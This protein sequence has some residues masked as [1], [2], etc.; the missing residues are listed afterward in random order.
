MI[1]VNLF[2]CFGYACLYMP[3]KN[4]VPETEVAIGRRVRE[5][6]LRTGLS[7]VRFAQELGIDSSALA[8]YEHGRVPVKYAFVKRLCDRFHVSHR[9][10]A[11]GTGEIFDY[12]EVHPD[13]EQAIS[14]TDLFS[15][16]YGSRLKGGL[17]SRAKL[18]AAAREGGLTIRFQTALGAP[19]S[20]YYR[21]SLSKLLKDHI[22]KVPTAKLPD[23]FRAVSAA[24]KKFLDES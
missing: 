2:M 15:E 19:D 10:L 11:D 24:S 12:D 22:G 17:R 1:P 14:P 7:Q 8:S 16:V 3:R 21:W 18:K 5:L 6:R 13:I 9:W 4:P 23:Y 20:D